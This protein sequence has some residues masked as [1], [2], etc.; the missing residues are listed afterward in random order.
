M[1]FILLIFIFPLSK[2]Q[3][4]TSTLKQVQS[5]IGGGNT[6]GGS[7]TTEINNIQVQIQ[8]FQQLISSGNTSGISALLN[9]FLQQLNKLQAETKVEDSRNIIISLIGN[10]YTLQQSLQSGGADMSSF[11]FFINN[12]SNGL[13]KI[14]AFESS[15]G[16][17]SGGGQTGGGSSVSLTNS[18]I[19]QVQ[20]LFTQIQNAFNSGS[21]Q[22]S[23]SALQSLVSL[24]QSFQSKVQDS[25][26]QQLLAS[27]TQNISQLQQQASSGNVNMQSFAQL[28][29]QSVNSLNQFIQVVNSLQVSGGGSAQVSGGGSQGGGSGGGWSWSFQSSPTMVVGA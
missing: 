7:T 29:M 2:I 24:L 21:V 15:G 9:T 1:C 3:N 23:A 20:S 8:N 11:Q 5:N 13:Q 10:I 6:G 18:D 16:S 12:I 26:A 4:I 27:I 25:N 28:L 14:A 22:S 19:S 17:S